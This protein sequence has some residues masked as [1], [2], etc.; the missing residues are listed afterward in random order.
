MVSMMRVWV[1]FVALCVCGVAWADITIYKSGSRWAILE[2]DGDVYISG[3]RVGEIESDGDVYK[4]GTR[5]GQ[6]EDD[7][8]IYVDGTRKGEIESDGDFYLGGTRIAELESDGDIYKGG[9]AGQGLLI[10]PGRDTVAVFTGYF[11]EDQSEVQA[12]PVIREVMNGVFG[13]I[14]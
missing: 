4:D 9:W 11:K 8:D 3:T 6:V 5:I 10:N 12:A 2:D 13:A 7:G 14:E 1:C